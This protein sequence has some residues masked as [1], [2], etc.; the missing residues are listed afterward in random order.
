MNPSINPAPGELVLAQIAST[1]PRESL[2][3][4]LVW[5]CDSCGYQR[6]APT[7]PELC[8][9]CTGPGPFEGHSRIAWRRRLA[10]S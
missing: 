8:P 1:D 4:D 6:E 5:R 10:R 9:A 7:A 2:I 3:T